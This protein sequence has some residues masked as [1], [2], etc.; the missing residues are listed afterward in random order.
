M[1]SVDEN[2]FLEIV[3]FACLDFYPNIIGYISIIF[4][5]LDGTRNQIPDIDLLQL[6]PGSYFFLCLLSFIFFLLQSQIVNRLPFEFD[7]IKSIGIKGKIKLELNI[8]LTISFFLFSNVLLISLNTIIPISL[9]YFENSGE[10]TLQNFWS[11]SEI[12]ELE[13]FLFFFLLSF[14]QIPLIFIFNWN[15]LNSVKIVSKFWKV[16]LFFMTILAGILTPTLDG[17]TQ[18]SF[19]LFT[20][21]FYLFLVN[22]VLKKS[23]LKFNS[24]LSFGG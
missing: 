1:Y 8:L 19:V 2:F 18:L 4:L 12:F 20:L 14:S 9:D 21:S 10:K 15:T 7:S 3:S 16:I 6:V 17:S 24:F 23:F 22:S 5:F 11:L 13:T